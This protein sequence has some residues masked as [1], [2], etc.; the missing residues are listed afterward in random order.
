[1][2]R[3]LQALFATVL[4]AMLTVTAIASLDR[5]VLDAG[6]GL[7]QDWWFRAT[8]LDAYFGFLTVYVWVAYR[9]PW[10]AARIVWAVAFALFGN[11]AIAVYL[12]MA[13]GRL[14]AGAPIE[15]LLL[16]ADAAG[17]RR[18]RS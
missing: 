15:S 14:P 5:S 3:A 13:L 12:L 1:M 4:I 11:I 8:L 9:E 6:A 10:W 18:G 7:W 2:R 17:A 16:R